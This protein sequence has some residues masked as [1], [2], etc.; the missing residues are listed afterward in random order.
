MARGTYELIISAAHARHVVFPQL[1]ADDAWAADRDVTVRAF[2][3][4]REAVPVTLPMSAAAARSVRRYRITFW[5][6]A[7]P[8]M[9]LF[10]MSVVVATRTLWTHVPVG[11]TSAN[12]LMFAASGL[13][14]SRD[15]FFRPVVLV[16]LT[17]RGDVRVRGVTADFARRTVRLNPA[18]TVT[19]RASHRR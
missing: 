13:Y 11:E 5:L 9:V 10:G 1:P 2:S 16:G 3:W 18:G 17:W 8:A 12:A 6:L 4:W 7:T 19:A 15:S 14:L